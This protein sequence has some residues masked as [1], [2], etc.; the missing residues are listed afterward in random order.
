MFF[1]S[2]D[3]KLVKRDKNNLADQTSTLG[4][5][6]NIAEF[7]FKRYRSVH[8]YGLF[9]KMT[10][11]NGRPEL[12]ILLSKGNDMWENLNFIYKMSDSEN[13]R[14]KINIPHQPRIDWQMSSAA[15]SKDMNSEPWMI[16]MLGKVFEK[17]PVVLDLLGYQVEEREFFYKSKNIF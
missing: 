17:N 10:G 12:D 2:I 1:T 7:I 11:I 9:K 13:F 16:I 3:L 15:L 4:K 5:G 8:G 6:V 14:L